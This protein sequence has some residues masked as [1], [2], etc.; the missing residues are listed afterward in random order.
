M[1]QIFRDH[2]PYILGSAAAASA[3]VCVPK[4]TAWA[5]RLAISLFVLAFLYPCGIAWLY[6]K[7]NNMGE[8]Y[9]Y[10]I[11]GIMLAIL[12]GI[13]AG[14]LLLSWMIVYIAGRNRGKSP[15]NHASDAIGAETAPQHQRR[16]G[17]RA[18][19]VALQP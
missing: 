19:N 15:S 14:A 2:L 3:L 1:N 17:V 6:A 13:I 18:A 8:S 10:L 16:P 7:R 12:L 4:Q 9:G 11:G 5:K